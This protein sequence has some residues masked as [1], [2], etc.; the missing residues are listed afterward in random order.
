[1]VVE[2]GRSGMVAVIAEVTP[3]EGKADPPAVALES[4]SIRF[5]P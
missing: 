3:A 4:A 5:S 1:M 2:R